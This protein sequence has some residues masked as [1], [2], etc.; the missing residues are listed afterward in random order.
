M[1]G[2]SLTQAQ[3]LLEVALFCTFLLFACEIIFSIDIIIM[4][5]LYLAYTITKRKEN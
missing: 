5:I 1:R 2:I 4:E 3:R